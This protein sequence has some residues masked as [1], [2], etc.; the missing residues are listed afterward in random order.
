MTDEFDKEEEVEPDFDP[1]KVK[2]VFDLEPEEDVDLVDDLLAVDPSDT[3]DEDEYSFSG[4]EDEN[5]EYSY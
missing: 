5:S 1:K 4:F 3:E 2:S